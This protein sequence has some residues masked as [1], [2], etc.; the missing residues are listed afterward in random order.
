MTSNHQFADPD[1]VASNP[2]SNPTFATVLELRLT[3]R[4][5]VGGGVGAGL[6]GFMAPQ[7]M[8]DPG[9]G[10]GNGSRCSASRASPPPRTTPSSCPRATSPRC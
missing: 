9:N 1:D 4:A 3:R 10:K 2:S 6:L 8:A 7:A 5:L